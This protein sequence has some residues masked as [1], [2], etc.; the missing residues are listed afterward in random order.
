M[1]NKKIQKKICRKCEGIG[2]FQAY[3]SPCVKRRYCDCEAGKRRKEF[4]ASTYPATPELVW[5]LLI[6]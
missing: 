3:E 4:V 5:E 6:L 2:H 1:T